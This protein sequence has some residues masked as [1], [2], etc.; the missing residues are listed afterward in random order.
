MYS[1]YSAVFLPG[2]RPSVEQ[3]TYADSVPDANGKDEQRVGAEHR[4]VRGE[5]RVV[6]D[7]R[8]LACVDGLVAVVADVVEVPEPHEQRR[9]H[10]AEEDHRREPAPQHEPLEL[11]R[12]SR[13]QPGEARRALR[14]CTL[15]AVFATLV[16]FAT[17]SGTRLS[18]I[19]LAGTKMKTATPR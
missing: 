5:L 15:A 16:S 19:V 14:A 9:D 11:D 12:H 6:R 7:A 8:T 10:D 18:R 17:H 1:R 3:T 4:E 2:N 13:A